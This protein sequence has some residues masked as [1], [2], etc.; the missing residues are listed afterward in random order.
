MLFG[1]SLKTMRKDWKMLNRRLSRVVISLAVFALYGAIAGNCMAGE[2]SRRSHNA[3]FVQGA[4]DDGC[5]VDEGERMGV[6]TNLNMR[7]EPRYP[8]TLW[9]CNE[10]VY[11]NPVYSY[12]ANWE[13]SLVCAKSMRACG[14]S[15]CYSPDRCTCD[16]DGRLSCR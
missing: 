6:N 12:C 11:Y 4:E 15:V 2:A 3:E 9:R 7:I 8:G 10:I 14:G 5:I 16:D 13:N 1:G